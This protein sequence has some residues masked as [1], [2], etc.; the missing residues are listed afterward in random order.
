[1]PTNQVWKRISAITPDE[2][3]VKAKRVRIPPS[4]GEK[5]RK[6]SQKE[7]VEKAEKVG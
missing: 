7:D 1:M 6:G 5:D 2:E 3:E 4:A